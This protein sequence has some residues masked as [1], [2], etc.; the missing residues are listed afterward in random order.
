MNRPTKAIAEGPMAEEEVRLDEAAA[1][2]EFQILSCTEG[3]IIS[4]KKESLNG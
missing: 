1:I 3:S 2:R 4:K